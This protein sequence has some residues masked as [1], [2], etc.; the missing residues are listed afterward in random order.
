MRHVIGIDL[1]GTKTAGGIVDAAGNVVCPASVP[2]PAQS[3]AAAVLDSTAGLVRFLQAEAES[4]GLRVDALGIGSAG[5]IDSARGVVLSATDSLRGWAGTAL[6]AELTARTGLPSTALNDVH[7]HALGE[8]WL[9]A[10]AGVP[11]VLFMGMG[12][13][14]GGSYV[15]EGHPLEG[16]SFAAGHMGHLA[17]P[18]A[19]ETGQPLACSCGGAGHLE[20]VASGPGIS[21]LYSRLGGSAAQDTREVY[22]LAADGDPLAGQA[23]R[24]GAE[25]AGSAI[26]GLA[27]VFDPDVVVVGGGLAFAGPLWWDA[28]ERQA[29]SELLPPLAGLKIVPAALGATAAIR[30]AARRALTLISVPEGTH[31]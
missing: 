3:G 8:S 5:V 6:T 29:R 7:A 10:G 24:R 19:W 27:N 21:A 22:R 28:M 30:G 13:G 23:L 15:L 4:R 11:G 18:F 2:T 14:V 12:T 9:G 25:A 17:S 20:A 26:G 31:A 16:A 1:G